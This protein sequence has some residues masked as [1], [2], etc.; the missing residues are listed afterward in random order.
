M[1]SSSLGCV[2]GNGDHSRI[3]WC[4]Y[5]FLAWPILY[6]KDLTHSLGWS[7]CFVCWYDLINVTL[8]TWKCCFIPLRHVKESCTIEDELPPLLEYARYYRDEAAILSHQLQNWQQMCLPQLMISWLMVVAE[9]S[10]RSNDSYTLLI[11]VWKHWNDSY[12]I[13]HI[14]NSY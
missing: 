9:Y 8:C 12:F 13:F 6:P 4:S 14:L 3:W 11:N 5:H 2:P 1:G 10:S 7:S